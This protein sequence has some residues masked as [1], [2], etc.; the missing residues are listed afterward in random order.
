VLNQGFERCK[1]HQNN[2]RIAKENYK[3]LGGRPAL[4]ERV[5]ARAESRLTASRAIDAG[6][7]LDAGGFRDSVRRAHRMPRSWPAP[8]NGCVALSTIVD[9][10]DVTD[11]DIASTVARRRV[12]HVRAAIQAP[13]PH[14]ERIAQAQFVVKSS[15]LAI[16]R[17]RDAHASPR[18]N[19]REFSAF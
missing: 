10:R 9:A 16:R 2:I 18:A 17:Y 15:I 6:Q 11:N 14:G 8:S 3:P 13:S 1:R 4:P 19:H 5:F 12:G 7:G